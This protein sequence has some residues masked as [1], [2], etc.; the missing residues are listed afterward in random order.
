MDAGYAAEKLFKMSGLNYQKLKAK[1][2][3]PDFKAVTFKAKFTSRI[4]NSVRKFS[5]KM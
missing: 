1:A 3:E 4:A 5:S 2:V